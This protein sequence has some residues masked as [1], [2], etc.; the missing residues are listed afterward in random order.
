MNLSERMK[1]YEYVSRD[2]LTKR[3][4]VIVRVDGKAFHTFTKDF[5]RPFDHI[6]SESM[7]AA[8]CRLFDEMQGCKLAYIQSDEASFV[9]TDY[10]DLG[11]QG[12]F[13]YNRSKIETISASC[14]TM[15]FNQCMRLA[16]RYGGAMFDARAFNVPP[17]EVTNYFLWRALDWHRN[18]IAMYA[19]ANFSQK[20][21][22]KKTI[23]DMHDMLHDI[24]KNWTLNLYDGERNG[25]FLYRDRVDNKIQED[26]TFL[27]NFPSINTLWN[28]IRPKEEE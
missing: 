2:Y 1:E 15:R 5:D 18:S 14:M 13:G 16:S 12:W 20:E 3:T 6:L 19:Q 4:P 25:T 11:T 9:L 10:D 23:S 28:L 7:I 27:P 21:L 17:D 22:H 26:S 24:G 8:A